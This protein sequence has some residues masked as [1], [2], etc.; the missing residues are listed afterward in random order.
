MITTL[1]TL[2]GRPGAR[3][4]KKRVGRG[5][6]SGHGTYSTRGL[7]GQRARSGGRRGLRKL[8]MKRIVAALPKI[9]GFVSKR[10]RPAQVAIANLKR[11]AA[12]GKV[13]LVSL[14]E[15]GLIHTRARSAKLVGTGT[16][17]AKLTI[18]GIAATTGARASIEKA[19]GTVE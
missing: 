5:N 12:G 7:K 19:G 18:S 4:G 1:H 10:K 11:F 3:R 16:V 2:K 6:A 17:P 9:G 8:G 15:K 13:T 14:K